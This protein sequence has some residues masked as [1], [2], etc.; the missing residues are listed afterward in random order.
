MPISID[1]LW[2]FRFL[3]IEL[4]QAKDKFAVHISAYLVTCIIT[5]WESRKT[6]N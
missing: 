4:Y 2:K 6:M 1:Y 5:D 3:I